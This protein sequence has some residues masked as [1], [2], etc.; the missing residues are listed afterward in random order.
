MS[1]Q[2]ATAGGELRVKF[3]VNSELLSDISFTVG[4]K[5]T[6][7]YG[8]R[9]PLAAASDVFY[10]MFTGKLA[11]SSASGD[12]IAVPDI[13]PDT[14]LEMLKFIY[15]DN[16]T[17]GEDNL[18]ELYY[19]AVKYNLSGLKSRCRQFVVR[20]EPSVLKI[21]TS[22]G[23]HG[24][25]E[26]NAA[27]LQTICANPLVMFRSSD[28]LELP[29]ELVEK[30]AG[31]S[32]HRCNDDQLLEALRKWSMHREGATH[33]HEALKKLTGIVERQQALNRDYQCRKWLFFGPICYTVDPCKGTFHMTA[34]KQIDLC[35]VGMY[36]GCHENELPVSIS[37]VVLSGDKMIRRL[38]ANVPIR[39]DIYVYDCMFE[40]VSL[41]AS[42]KV[43]I[44]CDGPR[45]T[46]G[47]L[48]KF[49]FWNRGFTWTGDSSVMKLEDDRNYEHTAIAYILYQTKHFN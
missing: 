38:Q 3:L 47:P 4:Q 6:V 13:E 18:V 12:P 36:I 21:F 34:L 41:R 26:L 27:C 15:Y 49:T 17:L 5:G 25:E 35:G 46:D 28:F 1:D 22:N 33:Q 48:K 14:F 24:F 40:R 37:V 11:P 44:V 20:E 19:A 16:P 39:E 2:E 7:I 8:H 42:S 32:K 45:K 10:R 31:Q 23:K 9:F 43:T 30:I 29:L